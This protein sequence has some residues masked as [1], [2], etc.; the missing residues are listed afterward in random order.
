MLY[1][2]IKLIFKFIYEYNQSIY[3]KY[4]V[5]YKVPKS[6]NE[7]CQATRFYTFT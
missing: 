1:K 4:R 7:E 5:K 6:A 2:L 3:F